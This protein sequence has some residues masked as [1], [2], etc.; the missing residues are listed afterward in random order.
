MSTATNNTTDKRWDISVSLDDMSVEGSSKT[1][2]L[3]T[4]NTY[5]DKDINVG[6]TGPSAGA[7]KADDV[8]ATVTVGTT[9]SSGKYTITASGRT[10]ASTISKG[11]IAA[12]QRGATGTIS[13][14]TTVDQ[15][16]LK[17]GSTTISSGANITPGSAQTITIGAGYYPSDR[18]VNVKAASTGT[19]ATFT[20]GETTVSNNVAT[21]GTYTNTAGY[22]SAGSPRL[23]AATFSNT[24]TSSVTYADVSE[25]KIGSASGSYVMPVID[26]EGYLY[27]NRGYVD[28]MKVSLARL[29]PDNS[30]ITFDSSTKKSDQMLNG[31][32]AYDKDGKLITGTIASKT[33]SDLSVSGATVSVPAGYYSSNTSASVAS[34]GVS[35]SDTALSITP[36]V[37]PTATASAQN[38]TGLTLGSVS[39]SAPTNQVSIKVT[40]GN[41]ATTGSATAGESCT[42]TKTAGYISGGTSTITSTATASAAE[43]TKDVYYPITAVEVPISIASAFTVSTKEAAS[44]TKDTA[45][46]LNVTNNRYRMASVTNAAGT[47][48]I[49]DTASSLS[50]TN[51]GYR[52]MTLTNAANGTATVTNS[53]TTSVTSGSASAGTLK[54]TAYNA[55]GTK[56]AEQEIVTSGKWKVTSITPSTS[57]QT[58]YGKVEVAAMTAG[59]IN[60]GTT[61]APSINVTHQLTGIKQS[62]DNAATS[63]YCT[64]G[65]ANATAGSCA[66][67]VT[68]GYISTGGSLTT[69]TPTLGGTGTV[70]YAT[71]K[72]S[73]TVS[74]T[75]IN[76]GTDYSAPTT[77][78]KSTTA[79]QIDISGNANGADADK[80]KVFDGNGTAAHKYINYYTG[81]YTVS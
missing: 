48:S 78:S 76:G 55:S 52:M 59:S 1:L 77:V 8:T 51:N 2:T 45:S 46:K 61:T 60:A 9:A 27:I 39:S 40:G 25:A 15:S 72:P 70:Y 47:S 49:K 24:A 32:T 67:T 73:G 53:G 58:G 29:I 23:A 6:I 62:T 12:S 80:G 42:V 37:T 63:Y 26:S 7:F 44:G 57:A 28:N 11:F 34:G 31:V 38:Q 66:Y 10:T 4:A 3:A 17:N 22:A 65:S 30:N 18:T 79:P 43:S 13:G 68:A 75:C 74:A 50:V 33:S 71:V 5:V 41:S 19:A 64:T 81:S 21:M 20:P 69:A 36:S 16:T 54:V 56:E 14:S 35:L